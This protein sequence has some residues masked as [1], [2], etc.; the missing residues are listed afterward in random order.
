MKK[1]IFIISLILASLS[2]AKEH[3]L[4]RLKLK[5]NFEIEK[6]KKEKVWGEASA[7]FMPLELNVKSLDSKWNF[8][9]VLQ[10]RRVLISRPDSSS[11]YGE[12]DII[13]GE[14]VPKVVKTKGTFTEKITETYY[15]KE[16]MYSNSVAKR[17]GIRQDVDKAIFSGGGHHHDHNHDHDH[18]HHEH[19]HSHHDHNH[20][21]EHSGN[22]QSLGIVKPR[23]A[24]TI[25]ET[26]DGQ[27][28][29]NIGY[30]NGLNGFKY[31]QY[32]T[33]FDE[34]DET[35]YFGGDSI[36]E[37]KNTNLLKDNLSLSF[38]PRIYTRKVIKPLKFELD[39]D[40]RYKVNEDTVIGAYMYNSAELHN[41]SEREHFKNRLEVFYDTNKEAKRFHKFYEV[42]DHEHDKIS[43]TKFNFAITH[44]GNYLKNPFKNMK[45]ALKYDEKNDKYKLET[46]FKYKNSSFLIKDLVFENDF[47]FIWNYETTKRSNKTYDVE[48]IYKFKNSEDQTSI[49][50]LETGR[51]NS[52]AEHEIVD[53]KLYQ[54]DKGYELH[55]LYNTNKSGKNKNIE[56]LE[57]IKLNPQYKNGAKFELDNSQTK[58]NINIKNKTILGYKGIKLENKLDIKKIMTKTDILINNKSKLE[59]TH[60]INNINIKPYIE[61]E[62]DSL[63][64]SKDNY[65]LINQV[66]PALDINYTYNFENIDLSLKFG[67]DTKLLLQ[68]RKVGENKLTAT[69]LGNY[70]IQESGIQALI[71]QKENEANK[72]VHGHSFLIKPYVEAKYYITNNFNIQTKGEIES[73]YEK[74]VLNQYNGYLP[75]ADKYQ[76]TH[77]A[78]VKIGLEYEY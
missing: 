75:K 78:K 10:G 24:K 1:T 74:S 32:I 18:E 55:R 28:K 72:W 6:V 23:G 69:Q 46:G 12:P 60:K 73:R 67:L 8:D 3:K 7:K 38:I 77:I 11:R 43:Q 4:F 44:E 36:L 66:T 71:K 27:A 22:R 62:F 58:N 17:E 33:S 53:K 20:D 59:Y 47:N 49:K 68:S 42:L 70:L 54:T 64:I 31:T 51:L 2:Y 45:D 19:D 56:Y 21:H 16:Y 9:F 57:I 37:I 34:K 39:T 63:Y 5:S 29:F 40:L 26:N 65:Y 41:L 25:K 50:D 14:Y 30:F 76:K 35:K 15:G 52:G 48:N 61:N 13:N